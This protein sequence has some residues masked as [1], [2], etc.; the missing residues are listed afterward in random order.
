MRIKALLLLMLL[1]IYK[2]QHFSMEAHLWDQ[3]G[4]ASVDPSF[5]FVLHQLYYYLPKGQSSKVNAL[6]TP[7]RASKSLRRIIAQ[8]GCSSSS[9]QSPQTPPP[10]QRPYG[11]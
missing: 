4:L 9:S 8:F 11:E 3:H 2:Y 5:L 7:H 6:S 1:K 10:S